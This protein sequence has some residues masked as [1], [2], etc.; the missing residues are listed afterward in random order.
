MGKWFFHGLI[1]INGCGPII[2]AKDQLF[3]RTHI[4]YASYIVAQLQSALILRYIME[5]AFPVTQQQ[6]A[7]I[8]TVTP[9]PDTCPLISAGQ[10]DIRISIS[11]DV[12]YRDSMDRRILRF[13]GQLS[14]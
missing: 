6:D 14:W 9:K 8:G 5:V 13:G 12:G 2:H 10:H 3:R 11:V 7:M 4:H 1:F